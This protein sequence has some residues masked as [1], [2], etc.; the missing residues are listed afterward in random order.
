MQQPQDR[1]KALVSGH[2]CFTALRASVNLA[3]HCCP[4]WENGVARP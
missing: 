4:I 3:T 2:A 1:A